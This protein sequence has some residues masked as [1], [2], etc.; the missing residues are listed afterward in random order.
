MQITIDRDGKSTVVEVAP[1]G[2]AVT[3]G[4]ERYSVTVVRTTSTS[5][6]L[7]IAGERVMVENW[8]DHF[9]DPPDRWT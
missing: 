7:E 6:E 9:P 3:V 1:G 8:P 4:S 5:V 2:D